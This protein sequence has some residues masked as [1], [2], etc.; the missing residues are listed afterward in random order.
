MEGGDIFYDLQDNC[1]LGFNTIPAVWVWYLDIVHDIIRLC[2]EASLC[3]WWLSG[4]ILRMVSPGLP[5]SVLTTNASKCRSLWESGS[6]R[7]D[8]SHTTSRLGGSEGGLVVMRDILP[9]VE[10]S[11]VLVTGEGSV[12]SVESGLWAVFVYTRE[13]MT[14]KCLHLLHSRRLQSNKWEIH[15]KNHDPIFIAYYKV[16]IFIYWGVLMGYF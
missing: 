13:E 6:H 15:S 11:S 14:W 5:V 10:I 1:Q 2:L 9:S 12:S 8:Q 16:F 4:E 3:C 7:P